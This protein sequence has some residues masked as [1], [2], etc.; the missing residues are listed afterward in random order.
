MQSATSLVKDV[1]TTPDGSVAFGAHVR[2]L[3]NGKPL[4]GA[5]LS[6]SLVSIE[7]TTL[8]GGAH[9]RSGPL[10]TAVSAD[11]GW[12]HLDLKPPPAGKKF[13]LRVASAYYV[14]VFVDFESRNLALP[15]S[16]QERL[17]RTEKIVDLEP[18]PTA[19]GWVRTADKQPRL[20]S[21]C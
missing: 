6:V 4:P 12:A 2:V 20:D 5:A 18:L 11:D 8:F 17:A 10:A 14:P 7:P 15:D 1:P 21:Q 9:D 16:G 3:S 13:K 19:K